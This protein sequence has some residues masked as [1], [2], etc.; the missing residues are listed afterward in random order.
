MQESE[1][2]DLPKYLEEKELS[3]EWKEVIGSLRTEKGWVANHLHNYQG[4]WHNTRQ[5]QGVLSCQKN[6]H[7][8]DTDILIVTTPKSG[9]TWLKAWTFA[10]LNRNQYPP[11]TQN[12]N[13]PLLTKNPHFLVPFLE[14]NLYIDKDT[15]PNLFSFSSPRLFSTHLPYVSLPKSVKDS[16][17][18]I[19]YLCRDPKDTFVSLWHFT[20]KLRPPSRGANS[21]EEAFDKFCRGVSLCG[22][23]W[24]HLLG[25]WQKSLEEPKKIMFMRFEEMKMKPKFVLKELARFLGC[26]FSQEEEDEGVVDDILKLCSFDNL[27][28]LQVNRD[29]KLS[30]GE[31]HQAFFRLGQIGDWKNHLTTEMI[32]QL[33]TI[34]EKQLAQ[35]GLRF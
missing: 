6:F 20:N 8:H 31:E 26:P 29:G 34:T 5:L 9:T 22:P 15:L 11:N 2:S 32:Q 4:F 33:H 12:P 13:H 17:C 14:L 35:Q 23:F 7:A 10:L 19:V 18:K 28:N 3:N 27:S 1:S 24:A 30:S 25:Y 16:T 21:L